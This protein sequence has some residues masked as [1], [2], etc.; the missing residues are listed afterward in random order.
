MGRATARFEDTESS[1]VASDHPIESKT[2]HPVLGAGVAIYDDTG[3]TRLRLML[4][5]CLV[6]LGIFG[7]FLGTGDIAHG[8]QLTG[9][10]QAAAGVLVAL[11]GL[12][13]AVVDRQHMADPVR[14]VIAR[15]GFELFPGRRATARLETF[16]S[17]CPISWAEVASVGDKKF[18]TNPR[19][20]R[21]QLEHPRDFSER[22]GLS[23][24]ARLYL[25]FNKGDLVLGS[26]MAMPNVKVE[27]V[28]QK[29]LAEYR[30]A[31]PA[32]VSIHA[33]AVGARGRRPPR[34]R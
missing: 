27:G 2:S 26:N 29:R 8:S 18:A 15:D 34:K 13:T 10:A 19:A 6:P 23:T 28:M 31:G 16:P 17:A 1:T 11:Y 5:I 4:E 30:G 9:S 20:V 32:G 14:L 33:A 24:F 12:R 21:V 22:H 7:V 3:K 25:R